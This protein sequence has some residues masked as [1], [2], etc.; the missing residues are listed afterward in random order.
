MASRERELGMD[1]TLVSR[2]N[3]GIARALQG[4]RALTRSELGVALTESG[5]DWRNDGALLAHLASAAELEAVICSG[6]LK[7]SQHTYALLD[8]RVPAAPPLARDEA[9]GELVARYF[10]SHGP[11]T[12]NDFAWWS[13]LTVSAAREAL[14]AFGSRF[15]SQQVGDLTYWF[16][17]GAVFSGTSCQ[18]LMLLPNY[19]EFTVAYRS[20]ELFYPREITYRPGP[21]YDAPF[22]NVIVVDG[23]VLG[24]WKRSVR[25]GQLSIE[26]EWFNAPSPT[27]AAGFDEAVKRY[28][29]FMGMAV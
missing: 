2:A 4:G 28:A 12:L 13:G 23:V 17:P 9:V 14:A 21:R 8:E 19:D 7:G 18:R 6:P 16:D 10:T 5:L 11:A 24:I 29:E 3:D 25:K 1:A 27:H 15:T 22:G 26:P 20:R